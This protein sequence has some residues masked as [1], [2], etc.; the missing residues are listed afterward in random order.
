MLR[1]RPAAYRYDGHLSASC[2][3]KMIAPPLLERGNNLLADHHPRHQAEQ[4]NP[5]YRAKA[6]RQ[7]KINTFPC[8]FRLKVPYC[9]T[10]RPR[11][12]QFWSQSLLS[13]W[14]G[15]SSQ[16]NALTGR[17]EEKSKA[18]TKWHLNSFF[19]KPGQSRDSHIV[20][21]FMTWSWEYHYLHP[22]SV[23]VQKASHRDLSFSHWRDK[24]AFEIYCAYEKLCI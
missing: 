15:A 14:E 18:S 6:P 9:L 16:G 23:S 7:L 4:C 19:E 8:C 1:S 3:V 22:T 11:V 12:A 24:E 20:T 10:A 5:S 17:R 13:F 2:L 21:S